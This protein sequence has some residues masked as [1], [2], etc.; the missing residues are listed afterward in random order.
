[1]TA[2]VL[3]CWCWRWC[4]RGKMRW[5]K[6][7][8]HIQRQRELSRANPLRQGTSASA[9]APIKS[10]PPL[11]VLRPKTLTATRLCVL[12]AICREAQGDLTRLVLKRLFRHILSSVLKHRFIA[13]FSVHS[14]LSRCLCRGSIIIRS[15]ENTLQL[16]DHYVRYRLDRP[17][18][19]SSLCSCACWIS[20]HLLFDISQAQSR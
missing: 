16:Y 19:A 9:T 5:R 3:A 6:M 7:F 4:K 20:H 17:F 8:E 13:S 1:M 14:R 12:S 15:R 18:S 10:L 11:A 2:S